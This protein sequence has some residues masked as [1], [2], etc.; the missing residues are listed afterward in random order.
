MKIGI[1][2]DGLMAQ[3]ITH[4]LNQNNIKCTIHSRKN[5]NI[6]QIS[7]TEIIFIC[8]PSGII[9]EYIKLLQNIPI[10]V[11]C[12]KGI[13]TQDSTTNTKY[14]ISQLFDESK[15]AVLSGPNFAKEIIENNKTITSL[16]S[17]NN[18]ILETVSKILGSSSFEIEKTNEVIGVEI[19]GIIKN[20]IAIVMGYANVKMPSWNEKSLFL[21]KMF[22]ETH[23][24]L[25]YFNCDIN[26]LN[27]SSGIGD[28]FLTCSSE[29]SRNYKFGCALANNQK[30]ENQTV[31]GVRSLEFINTLPLDLPYLQYITTL[32]VNKL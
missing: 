23:Q 1:L 15:F 31:E 17:K 19:C 4:L 27:L 26:V 18:Q 11:S 9:Q 6:E 25:Q 29:N 14:F 10:V 22:Q 30:L 2:G 16:A 13:I 28:I 12:A 21:T 3:A 32:G 24:V 20:I 8:I 5:N 7:N